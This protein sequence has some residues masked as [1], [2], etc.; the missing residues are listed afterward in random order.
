MAEQ[1]ADQ[2][3]AGITILQVG[4]STERPSLGGLDALAVDIRYATSRDD[5]RGRAGLAPGLFANTNT[6]YP[7]TVAP[8]PV[9]LS[10]ALFVNSNTFYGAFC[11]L[12]PFHPNDVRPGGGSVVPGPRDPLPAA[13]AAARG[14][15][16]AAFSPRAAMPPAPNAARASMPI[17]PSAPRQPMPAE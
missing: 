12:Y 1:R 5:R 2:Q 13:P 11:Y 15:M 9:T 14:A 10:P 3:Y 7:P 16:P 4:G 8:G 6:F 17:P